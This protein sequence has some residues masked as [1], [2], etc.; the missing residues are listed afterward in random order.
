MG[1]SMNSAN[2]KFYF[3]NSEK[4][5]FL[6]QNVEIARKCD[7]DKK[8]QTK[9]APICRLKPGTHNRNNSAWGSQW[10]EIGQTVCMPVINVW[11]PQGL[12]NES[13][14]I[15]RGQNLW[16]HESEYKR[17]AL[18]SCSA[19][20]FSH[21]CS[22][23]RWQGRVH[24]VIKC[25][26]I[27]WIRWNSMVRCPLMSRRLAQRWCSYLNTNFQFEVEWREVNTKINKSDNWHCMLFTVWL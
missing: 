20:F 2:G 25:R 12:E 16:C 21:R 7:T 24:T 13:G 4:Y 14:R 26:R 8:S 19:G 23:K 22:S 27:K 9:S 15:S 5:M 11:T 18:S 6:L 10:I 3:Q 1:K 17:S